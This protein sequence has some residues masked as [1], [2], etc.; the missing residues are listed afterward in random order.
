V[1]KYKRK[2]TVRSHVHSDIIQFTSYRFCLGRGRSFGIRAS[3]AGRGTPPRSAARRLLS[4]G[5]RFAAA[6][7]AVSLAH[8]PG[9]LTTLAV[10][11]HYTLARRLRFGRGLRGTPPLSTSAS[12]TLG[13]P[14]S[15][16]LVEIVLAPFK[17]LPV[18]FGLS[19][20]GQRDSGT[21]K[22]RP[23]LAGLRLHRGLPLV[24]PKRIDL[25]GTQF[26]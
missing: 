17:Q 21:C 5:R 24:G 26:P 3:L 20:V 4:A 18:R 7:A 9:F 16:I 15:P 12:V 1:R 23:P 11:F 19:R 25:V 14:S 6:Y 13:R 22:L 10:G 2:N 8:S